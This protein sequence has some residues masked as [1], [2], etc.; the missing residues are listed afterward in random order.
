MIS[1]CSYHFWGFLEIF[2]I[3]QIVQ[4][5]S[6]DRAFLI[7]FLIFRI[8]DLK[9]ETYLKFKIVIKNYFLLFF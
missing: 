2:Q 8:W 4:D 3:F 1:P 5:F 9:N 6:N 7:F